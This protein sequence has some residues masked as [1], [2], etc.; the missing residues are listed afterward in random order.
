MFGNRLGVENGAGALAP[1]IS[2]QNWR[3]RKFA[4]RVSRVAFVGTAV[5]LFGIWQM[6]SMQAA[7]APANQR[8]QTP[9]FVS[10]ALPS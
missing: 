5:I 8:Q 2:F 1:E 3:W 10:T 9:A 7:A 4:L 6:P